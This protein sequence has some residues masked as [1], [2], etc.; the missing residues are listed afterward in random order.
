MY[1][2]IIL[3]EKLTKTQNSM[4]LPPLQ[5]C[6]HKIIT[7]YIITL[8]RQ[9]MKEEKINQTPHK[10][11]LISYLWYY[12]SHSFDTHCANKTRKENPSDLK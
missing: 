7:L 9:Q 4:N 6:K 10:P 3:K 2:A 11:I 1:F 12:P 5:Y 8:S